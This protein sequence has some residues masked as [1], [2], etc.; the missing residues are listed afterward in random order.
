MAE[1]LHV[2][3]HGLAARIVVIITYYV[4]IRRGHLKRNWNA[5]QSSFK[6]VNRFMFNNR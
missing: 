5:R 1:A 4:N 6:S 3:P 2:R